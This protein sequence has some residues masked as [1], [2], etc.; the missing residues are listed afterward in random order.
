MLENDMPAPYLQKGWLNFDQT[1][2]E[3]RNI[4]GTLEKS[5]IFW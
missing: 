5:D 3:L 4:A 2:M 1:C